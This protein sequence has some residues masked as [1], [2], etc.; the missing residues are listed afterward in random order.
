MAKTPKVHFERKAIEVREGPYYASVV[1]GRVIETECGRPVGDAN[2]PQRKDYRG[3]KPNYDPAQVV[4]RDEQ[5][6]FEDVDC[7]SG[8]A[9]AARG[10]RHKIE[11]EDEAAATVTISVGA[12]VLDV[13]GDVILDNSP[14]GDPLDVAGAKDR[15]EALQQAVTVFESRAAIARRDPRTVADKIA[16]YNREDGRAG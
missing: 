16:A 2:S 8:C 15:I 5:E 12:V 1:V 7:E 3:E 11:V 6:R 4:G 14:H 9:R 10:R 13:S